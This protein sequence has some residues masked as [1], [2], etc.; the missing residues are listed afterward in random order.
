M[1]CYNGT[2]IN[3][4]KKS[5]T[6]YLKDNK[7]NYNQ[8]YFFYE[9]NDNNEPFRVLGNNIGNLDQDNNFTINFIIK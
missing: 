1:N 7:S 6:K 2:R 5:T 4:Q 8:L 9:Q 3:R